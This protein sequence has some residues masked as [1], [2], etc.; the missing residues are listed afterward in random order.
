MIDKILISDSDLEPYHKGKDL[1]DKIKALLIQQKNTWQLCADGY[2][3]LS[4]TEERKFEFGDF[5]IKVQFNPGRIIFSSANVDEKSVSN[6]KCILCFNHLPKEQQGI[7]YKNHYLILCNPFPIFEEHFTIPSIEHLPQLIDD[8][9]PKLLSLSKELGK[10]YIVFYNGPRCGASA[11]DHLHFQAGNK[12]F[13][14]IDSEYDSIKNK[15]GV[16]IV[17]EENLHVYAVD[18]YLRKFFSIE[19]GIKEVLIR[20]FESFYNILEKIANKDEEP[21]MNIL[22]TYENEKW[23][24]IIFPRAKHRPSYFFAEGDENILLSPAGVDLGG[25]LITPLEKDFKKL[26]KELITDIYNQVTISTEYFEFIKKKL[27]E[28][29]QINK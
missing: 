21:M 7:M 20:T 26:T 13:M 8:S 24:V 18:K 6:R 16:K 14:P 25:V 3:S 23:R 4:N 15:L 1:A 5:I 10:Y 12:F 28:L 17:N 11:P 9:F 22:S 27:K 19:S 29:A 2:K